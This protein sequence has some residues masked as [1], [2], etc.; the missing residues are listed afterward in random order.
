LP[1]ARLDYHLVHTAIPDRI[2]KWNSL[3]VFL[4]RH[5]NR[6]ASFADQISNGRE[7]TSLARD[8]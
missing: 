5:K 4:G 1:T 3:G 7:F 2:P 6:L 8:I